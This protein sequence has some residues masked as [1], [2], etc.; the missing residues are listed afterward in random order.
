MPHIVEDLQAEAEAAIAAMQAAARTARDLHARAELMRHM[1]TTAR[2]VMAMERE[3]A[4]DAVVREWMEAWHLAPA[5]WPDLA[6]EM[7]GFTAA[8]LDY[9]Q[10]PDDARDAAVRAAADGLEGAL[11]AR[12]S[13]IADEMA[14]RSMCAHRWWELVAPAPADL[15]GRKD[16]PTIPPLDPSRPFWETGCADR[17][18]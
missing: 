10:A 3:D 4:I 6:R 17:C 18:L 14:W 11:Q 12:G 9:V 8:C 15:P 2:K 7:R 13:S 1:R 5:D 16:R